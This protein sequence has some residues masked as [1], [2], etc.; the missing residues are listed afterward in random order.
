MKTELVQVRGIP[1]S[2][3]FQ[4]FVRWILQIDSAA[5]CACSM[6][7]AIEP[8]T[9]LFC[10]HWTQSFRMEDRILEI[11]MCGFEPD[12]WQPLIHKLHSAV[13]FYYPW[14]KLWQWS[15]LPPT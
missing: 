3:G 7:L 12:D 11:D 9:E 4:S 1:T 2:P 8:T 10:E 13:C 5:A 6:N 15:V 14:N